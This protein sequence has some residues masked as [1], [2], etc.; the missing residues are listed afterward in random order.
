V[1]QE[2][3]LAMGEEISALLP[4][5]YVPNIKYNEMGTILVKLNITGYFK[6]TDNIL[7]ICDSPGRNINIP[8]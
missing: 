8:F 5:I 4:E 2:G 1:K 3:C 6:H 7:I